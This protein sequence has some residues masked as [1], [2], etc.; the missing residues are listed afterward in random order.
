MSIDKETLLFEHITNNLLY[1]YQTRKD[2]VFY[3][4]TRIRTMVNALHMLYY[5]TA[6]KSF[7][8][9]LISSYYYVV[10]NI[11]ILYKHRINIYTKICT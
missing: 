10:S 7:Y 3:N 4:L 5:V 2:D 11:N 6:I 9:P 8:T 1:V